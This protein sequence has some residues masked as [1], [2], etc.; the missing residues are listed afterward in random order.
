MFLNHGLATIIFDEVSSFKKA[1]SNENVLLPTIKLL[2]LVIFANI[3]NGLL[4]KLFSPNIFL[5]ELNNF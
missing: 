1:A 2:Y 3:D 5:A 4:L